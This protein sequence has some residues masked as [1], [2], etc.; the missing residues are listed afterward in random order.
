[1]SRFTAFSAPA[2]FPEF[3]PELPQL[4]AE[5]LSLS[6]LIDDD[7]DERKRLFRAC[8]STGLFNLQLAGTVPGSKLVKEVDQLFHLSKNIFSLLPEVKQRYSSLEGTT[9]G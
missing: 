3:P 7:K 1:M 5:T 2:P 8:C 9:L 6:K 4:A